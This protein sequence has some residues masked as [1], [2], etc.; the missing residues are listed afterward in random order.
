MRLYACLTCVF[1]NVCTC[2]RVCMR[3]YVR[4]RAFERAHVST[5]AGFSIRVCMQAEC[6]RDAAGTE[7][8][9]THY[10]SQSP[11]LCT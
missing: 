8:Q 2:V 7:K 5:R 3:I 1:A 6:T 11:T 10:A 4:V 9:S